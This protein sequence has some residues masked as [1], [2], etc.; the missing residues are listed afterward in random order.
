MRRLSVCLP[1]SEPRTILAVG[2]HC[3]D[4]EIGAGGTLATWAQEEP[5]TEFTF[6]VLTSTPD[7]AAESHAC[8]SALVS[9]AVARI[10]IRGLRD[11]RLPAQFDQVKDVLAELARR[12]W[13]VVLTHQRYDAHQDHRLLGELATTAF[14]DHL[15]LQF[16]VPKWDGDLG[17]A[18]PNLYVPLTAG[19][20]SHKWDLLD[21]HYPSQRGKDWWDA[22]TF[23]ALARLRGMECRSAYAEAFRAEKMILDPLGDRP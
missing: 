22:E 9:P 6:V 15:V 19:Q 3:D 23:A 5:N 13:D 11:T 12:P 21:R 17:S 8:L 14:R 18:R 4:I 20:V 2:A 7:R 1:A 16:E 10:D